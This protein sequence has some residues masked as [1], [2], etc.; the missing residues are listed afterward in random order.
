MKIYLDP[1]MQSFTMVDEKNEAFFTGK[2]ITYEDLLNL[3][4]LLTLLGDLYTSDKC[5]GKFDF[6]N[7]WGIHQVPK[8]TGLSKM[9]I[10]K[11]NTNLKHVYHK[12]FA[13]CPRCQ[14]YKQCSLIPMARKDLLD[15]WAEVFRSKGAFFKK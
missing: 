9:D 15:L 14:Q 10:E 13:K 11:V 5:V 12:P 7:K 8:G 1:F 4:E 6:F 3:P 2:G